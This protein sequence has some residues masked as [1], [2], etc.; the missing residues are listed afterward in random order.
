M[1]HAMWHMTMFYCTVSYEA[2]SMSFYPCQEVPWKKKI[3]LWIH[4]SCF[5]TVIMGL[6][7]HK[8]SVPEKNCACLQILMSS[9]GFADPEHNHLIGGA[10]WVH[11]GIKRRPRWLNSRQESS[12]INRLAQCQMTLTAPW[13][14]HP[15]HLSGIYPGLVHSWDTC[16]CLNL[17]KSIDWILT[18]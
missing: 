7:C 11:L 3:G 5:K 8:L 18:F 17:S 6:S 14:L 9:W 16:F 4:L 1:Q 2:E 12:E 10:C 13:H 15:H